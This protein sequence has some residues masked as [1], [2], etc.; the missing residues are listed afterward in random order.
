MHDCS[1][2]VLL[3]GECHVWWA[4]TT[5]A[6]LSL[7]S[8]LDTSER[9]RWA[10]FHRC[11]D[12]ARYLTAHV[13]ARLVLAAHL[14]VPPASIRFAADPC[15]RCGEPHGKPRVIGD[16]GMEVSI[17]HSGTMA[18]IAAALRIPIG[19]DVE[20]L[21]RADHGS[22]AGAVLCNAEHTALA[23]FTDCD[24]HRALLGYCTRKEAL[25]KATGDGLTLPMRGLTVADPTQPPRLI[26]WEDRPDLAAGMR[27]YDLHPAAGHV[28]SLAA[29]GADLAVREF[30]GDRLLRAAATTGEHTRTVL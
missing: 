29:V 17:T 7:L 12:R 6:H 2:P 19:I 23:R 10:S 25:L 30:W 5:S 11:A 27:L 3:A 14:R 22:L 8:Y 9:T 16:T 18:G 21:R 13:L 20:D 28:A 26:A 4:R 15:R 24:R 1:P